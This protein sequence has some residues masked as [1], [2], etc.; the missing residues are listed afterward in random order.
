MKYKSLQS[1]QLS[2]EYL[3]FLQNLLNFIIIKYLKKE[4]DD[5]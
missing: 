4:V 3:C 1:G 5:T 2:Q